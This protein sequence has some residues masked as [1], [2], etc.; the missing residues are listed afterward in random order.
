MADSGFTPQEARAVGRM[1]RVSPRKLNL[2]V[3]E[4]RGHPVEEAHRR[5]A[6]SRRRIAQS[7]RKVLDSAVANADSNHGLDVDNLVVAGAWVGKNLTL[8]RL[9]AR[10]RGRASPIRKSFSQVTIVLRER[11]G[12]ES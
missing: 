5:L 3:S 12:E 7:V 9:R 1:L 10:A 6:G 8:R 4:I 11:A 2:V